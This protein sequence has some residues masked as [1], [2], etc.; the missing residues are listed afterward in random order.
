MITEIDKDEHESMVN[1]FMF[2]IYHE[3]PTEARRRTKKHE[4]SYPFQLDEITITDLKIMMHYFSKPEIEEYEKSQKL[5]EL[6]LKIES[7]K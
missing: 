2:V 5:K 3:T 4:I 7:R 6:L 1:G